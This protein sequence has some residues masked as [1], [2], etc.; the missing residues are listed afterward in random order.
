MRRLSRALPFALGLGLTLSLSL[1]LAACGGG[2]EDGGDEG[3]GAEDGDT[4]GDESD[5]GDDESGESDGSDDADDTGE[6]TTGEPDPG[7]AGIFVAVGDGGRRASSNDALEWAE[8]VGS[9]VFDT[10]AEMGEEDIL[11][12]VAAGDGAVVAVGGGGVDWTGNAMVMRSTDGVNWDEDLVAGQEGVDGRKLYAV[13]YADGSFVAGG[14]Q[15]HLIASSDGGQTWS[16][17]YGEHHSYTPVHGVAGHGQIFVAVGEHRD[18]YDSPRVAYVHRSDDGGASFGAP[19]YFGE[20]GD[21][22]RTVASNGETFVAVGP[23]VCLRSVDGID[24]Q[25]CGLS[26]LEFG[27]VS[28]TNDRFVVTYEDGLSTSSDG[29]SWS[30]HVESPTRVPAAMVYGNGVYA[31]LR[32]Y[33]RGTSEALSEWSY[34]THGSFPLRSLAFLPLE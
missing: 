31:G 13:G 1:T 33:D 32:Y 28:F 17:A 20:D 4:I 7:P 9:G 2:D 27:A 11:R 8:I 34:V 19:S 23:R 10:Q 24:W 26:A 6:S 5:T 21:F 29:E 16:S 14:A 25:D 15:T 22:L 3:D 30:P 18:E 12:A